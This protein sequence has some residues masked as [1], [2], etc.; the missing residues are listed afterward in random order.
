VIPFRSQ[1]VAIDPQGSF[2]LYTDVGEK[3]GKRV[4]KF[5]SLGS[6]A[7]SPARTILGC[8]RVSDTPHG[9]NSLDVN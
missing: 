6:G 4:L 1:S 9:V 2:F 3:C 7:V 8:S 5:Q